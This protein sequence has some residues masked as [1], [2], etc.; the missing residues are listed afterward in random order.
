M[1]AGAHPLR[2]CFNCTHF[3][4]HD[5]AGDLGYCAKRG[6][7]VD[8]SKTPCEDFRGVAVEEL[9]RHVRTFGYVYCV[10]C[11]RTLV[12]ED[13][14]AEHLKCGHIVSPGF[15]RDDVAPEEIPAAD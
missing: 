13:E 14:A 15:V 8:C 2:Q 3:S 10:T 5:A 11:R 1:P 6:I 9:V 7:F 12:D 4:P